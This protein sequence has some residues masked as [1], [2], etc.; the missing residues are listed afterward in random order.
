MQSYQWMILVSWS[1]WCFWK[2]P[3]D[4]RSLRWLHPT[5][6]IALYTCSPGS[7]ALYPWLPKTLSLYPVLESSTKL[8]FNPPPNNHDASTEG[9]MKQEHLFFPEP[10]HSGLEMQD[11]ST[12]NYFP[13]WCSWTHTN[14]LTILILGREWEATDAIFLNGWSRRRYSVKCLYAHITFKYSLKHE[15]DKRYF[16]RWTMH[17]KMKQW[18][19]D[20]EGNSFR[21]GIGSAVSPQSVKH[22]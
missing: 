7:R 6:Q 21:R 2:F 9:M 19:R 14:H 5:S 16:L 18:E 13:Y 22:F 4:S 10:N 8:N 17:K 12:V 1:M 3:S 20:D 15:R 11:P